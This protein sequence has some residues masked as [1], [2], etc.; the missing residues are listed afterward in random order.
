MNVNWR[1]RVGLAWLGL[2]IAAA[3]VYGFWPQP[4]SV[5]VAK[6]K[7][8]PLEVSVE[9]E[10]KTRVIDRYI[11]AS[12]VAGL[13]QRI[14]RKVGDSVKQGTP[15]LSIEPL[16]PTA[17]DPRERAQARAR[18][19]AAEAG[20]RAAEA[21]AQAAQVEAG[22]A[23]REA[24]RVAKLYAIQ[25][26]SQ[27]EHDQA[28]ARAQSARAA[29]RS[30]TFAVH[31]ARADLEAA[32]AAL[33]L[34]PG[35]AHGK[36]AELV[37][38][39]AP[40]DGRILRIM[41]ES[42]GPVQPGTPLVE[43]GDPRSLEVETDVL[44]EN[45]VQM[46]PGTPVQ[47]L[48]WGGDGVLH[49]EVTSIEPV[50]TT[51]VSALGVEEQ[52]VRVISNLATAPQHWRGLGDGYRVEARFILW[53]GDDVLQV[54]SS[55]LFRVGERWAVFVVRNGRAQRRWVELGHRSGLAA[56]V[57]HGIS[58]GDEVVAYPDDTLE[59]G[60]RVAIRAPAQQPAP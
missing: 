20:L 39:R 3:L 11:V 16:M 7:R 12:P 38:V 28:L 45:A 14:E 51:K 13:A 31:V 29:Q 5:D 17:L 8:A 59:D 55:A 46:H 1:R 22:L 10:G 21:Q 43:L 4:T 42:E 40:V 34:G 50:A 35:E 9:E 19:A 24:A 44:S 18:V 58:A 25:G 2:L 30:A 54:P 41:H 57:T 27:Q 56:Q 15:L 33:A 48:R 53:R 52:R 6:A 32:R 60:A 23:E 47:Y 36:P 26:I 49:G 37:R